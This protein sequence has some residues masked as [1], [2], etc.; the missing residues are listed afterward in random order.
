MKNNIKLISAII[1]MAISSSVCSQSQNVGLNTTNPQQKLHIAGVSSIIDDN[2]GTTA[3]PLVSP[4]IRADGLNR[5]NNPSIFSAVDTTNPLY[6]NNTGDTFVKK[7]IEVFSYT[8]PG[9]DAI[10]VSVTQNVTGGAYRITGDL[11]AVSFTLQHK[12]I[13]NISAVLTAEVLNS[14]GGQLTDGK[15]KAIAGMLAFTA[16]PASSGVSGVYAS[17]GFVYV[18]RAANAQSQFVKLQPVTE[19]SLPAGDYTIVIR[20]AGQ[21]IDAENFRVIWG[22]GSGDKLNVIARPL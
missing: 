17:D 5:V 21:A 12:S 6:V 9:S 19:V 18:N 16:A 11:I 15:P 20:G 4:T 22:P 2:I 8:P 7:G 14:T 10:P 13:V 1:G 3:L